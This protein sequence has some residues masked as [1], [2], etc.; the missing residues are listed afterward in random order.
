MDNYIYSYYQKIT[1]GTIVVGWKIKAVY[2]YVVKGLQNKTFYYDARKAEKAI[3][4][5]ENYCRHHEGR[6]GG[7]LIVLEL[8]QKALLS[9][10][11]GIVDNNNYRQ[12]REVL[13][14]V[15][16]KNG[17][18][19]FAS[20]IANYM[21]FV[22]GEYGA[23][24]YF[25]APKLD[26][27]K[28]C[29]EAFYQMIRT[30]EELDKLSEKRR[31]DV[32]VP[33]S[34][35]S[36]QAIPFSS[37]K[38][39]GLNPHLVVCDEISSWAGETGLRQYEVLKSALGARTQPLLLSITTAGY[40]NEGV[41]DEL[42]LRATRLLKGDSKETRLIAFIYD[43]DDI[44]KWDDINELRKSNPNLGVSVSVDYLLEEIRIATNSLSKKAEFLT[45][46]CNV[47]QNS[48]VAWLTTEV[49]ESACG[50]HLDLN[51]FRET[52]AVVG[53]D[54][55]RTTDLTAVTCVIERDGIEN[56][57]AHFFMP[58]EKIEEASARD[59][60]PYQIYV[61]K[62]WLTLCEG[63]LVDYRDCYKWITDLIELYKI[64]PLYVG[65]DRYSAQY[66]ISDLKNYGFLV[67][68][69]FQGFNLTPIIREFEGQIKDKKINI[70]DNNLLKIHLLNAALKMENETEKVKL[71][72]QSPR[73]HV[74]G[75]AALLD[76][77]TVKSKYYAEIGQ[78][79]KNENRKES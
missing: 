51:D 30:E 78:Q 39:D 28:L 8:W 41:Y 29:F 10:V 47:K 6:M 48:S 46:Y 58:S 67:D 7:Q 53:I 79:L 1:E 13:L 55:S 61:Q 33:R 71:I 56:V 17:K 21:T 76:A 23:R 27:A 74:D 59:N 72:K 32:Y 15:G 44:K 20:A 57:F 73:D 60:L 3:R 64:Y 50:E 35:S 2:E 75:V 62:G 9:V 40:E 52:Y 5:I 65:Y 68:D 14:I 34:N 4:F 31:S 54:L 11:F 49:V 77:K 36:A 37:K 19:L 42:I 69:V 16:R 45:K 22:D 12:F 38:T 25:T 70:G 43:I 63:N 26:Q 24:T 18:T 66:L